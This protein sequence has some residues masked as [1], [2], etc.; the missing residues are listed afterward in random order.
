M[1][2]E[3]TLLSRKKISFHRKYKNTFFWFAAIFF[4]RFVHRRQLTITGVHSLSD[5]GAWADA[6]GRLGSGEGGGTGDDDRHA[7][8]PQRA[9]LADER[10]VFVEASCNRH[11]KLKNLTWAICLQGVNI[12]D[13]ANANI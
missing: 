13:I 5:V 6:G 1:R 7:G 3:E 9:V 8:L 10:A 11:D 4:L 12:G 2:E